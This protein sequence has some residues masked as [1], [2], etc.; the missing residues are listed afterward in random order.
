MSRSS[1]AV[2]RWRHNT[3]VRMLIAMGGQ[4]VC[5]G[6][7][8][9]DDALEF[10]HI[11]SEEKD[12]AMGSIRANPKNWEAAVEELRK[13]VLV[14]ANCHREIHAGLREIPLNATRFDESCADYKSPKFVGL[15]NACPVCNESKDTTHMTCSPRCAAVF[16]TE[17]HQNR[18]GVRKI[19]WESIDLATEL[20][21]RSRDDLAEQLGC[22]N[23]AVW[24]RAVKL[25]IH[26]RQPT[27]WDGHD[28]ESLM[29]NGTSMTRIAKIVGCSEAAVRKHIRKVG[30]T[31]LIKYKNKKDPVI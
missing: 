16:R 7:S 18:V 17:G 15:M 11:D 29:R 8:R 21:T 5:C 20:Q 19:D 25:G 24:K 9:C 1:D 13:C 12:F 28:V 23:A 4:C 27:I 14:C 30:L 3:K 31:H 10:H 22:S 2:K 6:Y 26:V